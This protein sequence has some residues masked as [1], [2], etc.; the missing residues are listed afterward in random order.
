MRSQRLV[1]LCLALTAGLL[2]ASPPLLAAGSALTIR[3]VKGT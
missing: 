1:V 3:F 2:F